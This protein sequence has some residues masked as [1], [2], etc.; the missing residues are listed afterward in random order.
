[1]EQMKQIYSL[2]LNKFLCNETITVL[3][4]M[5]GSPNFILIQNYGLRRYLVNPQTSTF[6][7]SRRHLEDGNFVHRKFH[8]EGTHNLLNLLWPIF[9]RSI[10]FRG[11]PTPRDS[12]VEKDKRSRSLYW[13]RWEFLTSLYEVMRRTPSFTFQFMTHRSYDLFNNRRHLIKYSLFL[14]RIRLSVISV[15]LPNQVN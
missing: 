8:Q 4:L 12:I 13:P 15:I 2:L 14:R 11:E 7:T 6:D 1:M 9:V 10:E 5:V 3:C